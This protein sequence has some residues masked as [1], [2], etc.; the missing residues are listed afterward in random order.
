MVMR[1]KGHNE[2]CSAPDCDRKATTKLYCTMHYKR[3]QRNGK[4][5]RVLQEYEPLFKCEHCGD[6]AR[7]FRKGLCAPCATR[8]LRKGTPER[9]I[10]R[11]GSGTTTKAGY[12]LLTKNGKR[13]YEHRYFMDAKEGEVVHHEKERDNNN[14]D[15]LRVFPSQSEHMKYHAAQKRED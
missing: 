5:E 10:A 1:A 14:A 13:I 12:R 2:K 3:Y 15:N 9:T 8:N 4:P 11:R 6:N 7:R